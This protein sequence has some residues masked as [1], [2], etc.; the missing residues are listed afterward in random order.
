VSIEIE[1]SRRQAQEEAK[2]RLVGALN[3]ERK[4]LQIVKI[5]INEC[6]ATPSFRSLSDIEELTVDTLIN[7]G[8][9][10]CC[11]IAKPATVFMIS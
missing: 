7:S 3:G 5:T 2:T 11:A 1:L 10:A 9:G 4:S 6:P 8:C